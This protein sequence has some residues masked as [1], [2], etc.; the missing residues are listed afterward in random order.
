M[1]NEAIK[2]AIPDFFVSGNK[3]ITTLEEWSEKREELKELFLKT[4]YGKR[5]PMLTPEITTEEQGVNFAN[6]ASWESVFFKFKNEKGE[7]TVRTELILPKS[8]APV[9][10]FLY[11]S[12]SPDVPNKYLPMEE[13]LDNGFGVFTFY[14]E[15]VTTDNGDFEN[16]LCA[17]FDRENEDFGKITIWSYMASICMDYLCTRHEVD[18]KNVAVVGH[19]RLGKTALLTSAL[20]ERFV[21]TCSNESGCCGVAVSRGKTDKNES[22]RD[23]I[24]VFPFW[25]VRDFA[26]YVDN[27]D[28][29][30][31]DQHMLLALVAPRYAMVGGAI[32]DVWADNEGQLLSCQLASYAWSLYGKKGFVEGKNDEHL[33]GE[34]CFHLRGGSHFMSRYDWNVY[35][36]K[37][38]MILEGQK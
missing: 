7:H 22:I 5:P 3:K 27:E 16:G 14:Y 38:K 6:K 29:L 35:M 10:V 2:R 18:T 4:E 28:Q 8:E 13:I 32:E 1:I 15:N 11:I 21:L 36:R 24:R 9:P 20:D 34:A 19:S 17:L 26:K 30:P 33:D 23:I 25:F 31:F 12:F 37:F